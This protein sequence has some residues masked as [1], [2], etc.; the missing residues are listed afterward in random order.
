MKYKLICIDVDG[1][2][3]DSNKELPK[4]N[5]KAIQEAY[6]AGLK[7][8]IASGRAP[9]SVK[10]ILDDLGI[11]GYGICLNGAY[12]IDG[13]DEVS[14][15]V[16]NDEQVDIIHEIVKKYD[17]RSFFATSTLNVTNKEPSGGWLK[18]IQKSVVK[19]K[20]LVVCNNDE[21]KYKLNNY[22]GSLLK[23]SIMEEDDDIYHK[24]RE[25]LEN[26]KIF[27]VAKSDIHY[28]DANV[29]GVNKSRGVKDLAQHLNIDLS[30]VIC[31]GDNENDIDMIKT[32]GLGV[33]MANSCEELLKV[34]D[35][36]TL[37]NDEYGVAK[38]IYDYVLS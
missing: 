3:V 30:E 35:T 22:R 29:K 2:L 16:F 31:V 26:T 11:E 33:A 25:E 18:A 5:I 34:C 1:S 32:A 20:E 19:Q 36:V 9:S 7:I 6:K 17:V 24:V 37:S 15:Y 12:I 4:E 28:I 13:S 21:L 10:E 14:R 38:V 27:D 8:A 23:V